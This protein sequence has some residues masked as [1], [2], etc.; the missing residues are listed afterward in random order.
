MG[1]FSKTPPARPYLLALHEVVQQNTPSSAVPTCLAW[2]RSAKHPQL[3]RTY[4]PC[5]RSFSKTP[6]ARPYLLAL[7][8]VVQQNTPSSAVPT[9]LAWGRSAKHPQLGRTYLPCMRSFSKTPPAR[10]YLL[11][12]HEV[13]Q[14]NTPSSAVPTCLAWGRSAKHPQLGRTYLPCMRSF[15]KTPPARPYLLALHGVVQQNTPSSAVPTCLAW[16]RSAKHPQLGRTYLPCMR[17]FSKTP[18][19]RPYLLALHEVVQQNT[20]SSAVP[21][22]LAWGRSAKHPQLGRTYLP[23]MGSFSK[24]PP[25]RP[26]LLALHGVVQQNTPSSAVPTCLA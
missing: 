2:G 23:C 4:L 19:A 24:T 14:Q 11:A 8:E 13:V 10:P 7:H 21:T 5:M 6:P 20:P 3:G 26:Y 17:S 16:G 18:P 22:C 9:C 1:S 25:A 15:S 12:L